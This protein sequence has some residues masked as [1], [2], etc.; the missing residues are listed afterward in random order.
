MLNLLSRIM[1][2]S[3]DS[4]KAY[5]SKLVSIFKYPAICDENDEIYSGEYELGLALIPIAIFN[6]FKGEETKC[7]LY[8]YC[9]KGKIP[10]FNNNCCIS[11]WCQSEEDVLCPFG[12]FWYHYS[13]SGKIIDK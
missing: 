1:D 2:L 8:Q 13:L 9:K 10:T 4:S 7:Y 3:A 6:E 5:F 11:P 12:L